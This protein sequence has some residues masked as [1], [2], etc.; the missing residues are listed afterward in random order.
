MLEPLYM[1]AVLPV[2]VHYQPLFTT[3]A[4]LE[5]IFSPQKT[6]MFRVG[7]HCTNSS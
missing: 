4:I 7:K 3:S 6:F 1:L 2:P 5:A